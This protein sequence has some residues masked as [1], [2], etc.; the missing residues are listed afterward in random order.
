M[1]KKFLVFLV[2]MSVMMS[3]VVSVVPVIAIETPTGGTVG[4]VAPWIESK[5]EL[6]DDSPGTYHCEG[7]PFPAVQ[8]VLICNSLVTQEACAA[9]SGCKWVPKTEILP[10]QAGSKT[11]TKCAAVCDDNSKEDIKSVEATVYY[12]E[13]YDCELREMPGCKTKCSNYNE[14][15][16][17]RVCIKECVTEICLAGKEQTLILENKDTN[18]QVIGNDNI[19]ATLTYNDS[20]QKFSYKLIATG[21]QKSTSYSLIY[22]ADFPPRFNLWGGNNPGALIAKFTTDSS[23]NYDSNSQSVDLGMSLPS[24]PDWNIAPEPDYCDNHNGKDNYAN[25]SGAKIWLVP[26]IDYN[27]IDKKVKTWEQ[28]K[29]LFETDLIS[30]NR[31]IKDTETLVEV[32]DTNNPCYTGLSTYDPEFL[33]KTICK[34][35]SGTFQMKFSDEPGDYVVVIKAEDNSNAIDLYQNKFK[36]LD[37]IGFAI[38]EASINFGPLVPGRTTNLLGDFNFDTGNAECILTIKNIG[39]VPINLTASATDLISGANSIAKNNLQIK[40]DEKGPFSM[41]TARSY[42]I[43]LLPAGTLN[44]DASLFVPLGTPSGKY[45]GSL[46]LAAEK[47]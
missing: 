29:F 42:D 25:C 18:W 43:K 38:D 2:M 8:E 30:Y 24:E 37:T 12:P 9:I 21:L 15:Q 32:T 39:N 19:Q 36:Y 33:Q 35:Y 44:F 10:V 22:Y 16:G 11:V 7:I 27:E 13:F 14:E 47:A 31:M 1:K 17:Y 46:T 23:G 41:D 3:L 5:W 34:L 45:T 28:D 26:S 20:G 6:L 40:I 4:N